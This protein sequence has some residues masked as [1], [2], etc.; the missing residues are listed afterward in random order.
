VQTQTATR[1]WIN[2]V[3]REE[4]RL[5]IDAGAVGCTQNPSFPWKMISTEDET[6]RLYVIG[7]LDEILSKHS[8][9]E[10]S[11]IQAHLQRALVENIAK[12]FLP[13]YKA[14][15]GSSGYVSIQGDPFREDAET[16]LKYAE[17]NRTAPNIMVKI[18]VTKDGLEAVEELAA[19]DFPINATEVMSVRQA[20]DV[21]EVYEKATRGKANK[22]GIYFSHIAGIFDEYLKN[23]ARQNGVE[24]S[25]D[26]LWQ[27]GI[28]VAKK[29]YQM[30]NDR[31]VPV[32]FISGGARGLHHFTEMVGAAASVTINWKGTADKLIEQDLP[33]VSRF[34]Q[35]APHAVIE[36]LCA[37]LPDFVKAY[38]AYAIKPEEYEEFGP[39]KLFRSQFEDAWIK[40]NA[41][42]KDKR[43]IGSPVDHAEK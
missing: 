9:L 31:N 2:N 13:L 18:P 11:E 32:G 41:Y 42:I 8:D 6:E 24:I 1:F 14:S 5:A 10:E 25:S 17:F 4:V 28:T 16:I 29:I 26:A 21:V 35:P 34:L 15:G 22:P 3:T 39:V 27:G 30:A 38:F 23:Y 37:K 36:E 7:I 19:R 33:I 40:A 12:A 43:S 20:L